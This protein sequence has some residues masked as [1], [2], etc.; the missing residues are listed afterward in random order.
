MNN[1]TTIKRKQI[2]EISLPFSSF[3]LLFKH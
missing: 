3:Y 1:S 2:H